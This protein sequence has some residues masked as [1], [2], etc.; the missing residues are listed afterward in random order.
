M[1]N[2]SLEITDQEYLIK[3]SREDFNLSFIQ[4]LLKRIQAEQLFFS[5]RPVEESD[6]L[7]SR[8][9]SNERELRFDDLRDK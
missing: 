1:K 3:L 5:S 8:N 9:V 7:I 6:D 2:S 4:Q